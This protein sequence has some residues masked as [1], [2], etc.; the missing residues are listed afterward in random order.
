[1]QTQAVLADAVLSCKQLMGRY[2]VGFTDETHTAQAPGLPNHVA[3]CL[4]H[5]AL[6]MHRVAERLDGRPIPQSDFQTAS[7][8]PRPARFEAESVAF[9]SRPQGDAA[10]YPSLARCVEIF[11]SACDRLAEGLRQA[12]EAKLTEPFTWG[13]VET[14]LLGLASRMMFHNGM[15]TGQIADLR[16]ALGMKSIFA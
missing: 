13:P 8:E 10:R 7:V 14:T 15:H 3:W 9:G 12:S 2:L 16:R 5:C 11:H 4:G 1:M 6:T